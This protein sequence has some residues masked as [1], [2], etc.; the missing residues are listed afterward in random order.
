MPRSARLFLAIA[1]VALPACGAEE[2]KAG[3]GA[4]EESGV[5]V[6]D[7]WTKPARAGQPVSAAYVTLC[8]G[9]ENEDALVGVSYDGAGAVEI[10]QTAM[11]GGVASMQQ[12][13]RLPL[14]KGEPV[15]MAPGGT[16]LML[17]G[18]EDA[19]KAGDEPL[20]VFEFENAAPAQFALEVRDGDSEADAHTGH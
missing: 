1:L 7:A 16:H 11:E 13:E 19:L 10:H 6:L 15:K 4:C 9:G 12:R 2:E 14:P 8:N 17:I 3:R 20:F 5:V 18:V